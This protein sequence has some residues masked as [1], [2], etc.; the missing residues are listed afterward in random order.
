LNSRFIKNRSGPDWFL[1][2][3]AKISQFLNGFSIH[4]MQNYASVLAYDKHKLCSCTVCDEVR[5]TFNY[6]VCRFDPLQAEAARSAYCI[7][8]VFGSRAA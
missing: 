3:F 4:A 8:G 2:F 7:Y 6:V 1:G 5:F